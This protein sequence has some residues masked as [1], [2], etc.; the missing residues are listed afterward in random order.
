MVSA[1]SIK[2]RF[3]ISGIVFSDHLLQGSVCLSSNTLRIS[4]YAKDEHHLCWFGNPFHEQRRQTYNA[5]PGQAA[6][7]WKKNCRS[8]FNIPQRR[9]LPDPFILWI[10]DQTQGIWPALMDL[11]HEIE[12]PALAGFFYWGRKRKFHTLRN[13]LHSS[14]IIARSAAVP[15][16]VRR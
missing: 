7:Y 11:I 15:G 5:G 16:F 6:G 9:A 4:R 2:P 1:R 10:Q 13:Y 12:S 8:I 3:E 14:S